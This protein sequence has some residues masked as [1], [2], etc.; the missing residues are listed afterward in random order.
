VRLLHVG[1]ALQKLGEVN[2]VVACDSVEAETVEKASSEFQV[3]CRVKTLATPPDGLR[4]RINW[5]LDPRSLNLYSCVADAHGGARVCDGLT[6]FDLIWIN[7]LRVA[8]MFGLWAWPRSVLDIDDVPSAYELTGWRKADRLTDRLKAGARML[9][10][11]R[12]ERLLPERFTTLAVCSEADRQ[13][14]GGGNHIHVIPNGFERPTAEPHRQ[15][16]TPPRLGFIGLF[17]YPPNLK[18][19][20]WFLRECWPRIKRDI[21][22]VH[23]RLVGKDS[24][25]LPKDTG[26]DV[27]R[28]GWMADPSD[29][30]ATWSAMIV[31]IQLG[32][33]TRVKVAEAF[34]RKVPL[35]ST[36]LGAYGYDVADG[37][38]LLL[39][40][41]PAAFA[42]ACI[43]MIR[44]P[45]EAATMAQRAWKLFLN[46][47]TWDVIAPRVWSAAKHCLR[48]SAAINEHRNS[49][50]R[51]ARFLRAP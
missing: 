38:E 5:W 16:V 25:A 44:E 19:V 15:S 49:S 13:Y 33:G 39:A 3:Y 45:G 24:D 47:W 42:R 1:R 6:N 37:K 10:L 36:R 43:H 48:L 27:E 7:G 23:L 34:S 41:T 26:P 2:L 22:D 12:R 51:L 50:D 18:G 40:D 9:P 4:G 8:N 14:L 35:V 32:A 20:Q 28:L 11:R 21:P 30:I 17:S 46:N 29:E 31:P